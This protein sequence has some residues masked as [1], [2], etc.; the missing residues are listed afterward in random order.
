MRTTTLVLGLIAATFLMLGG[1]AGYVFGAFA[2]GV[3]EAFEIEAEGEGSTTK[4]VTDAG[5]LALV[6]AIFLFVAAGLAKVAL[7]MSLVM[8]ALSLPML[9]GLIVVDTYSLFAV[10]YYLAV[11]LV[12]ICCI[13]M[14]LAWRRQPSGASP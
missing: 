10:T 2:G 14:F 8:L 7:R 1:C 6:V 13:L 3:E 11:V 9:I 12:G 4:E 5:A